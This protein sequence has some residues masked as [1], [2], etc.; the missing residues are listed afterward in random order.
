[1]G[2]RVVIILPK[3]RTQARKIFEYIKLNSPQNAKKFIINL[4]EKL[5]VIAQNPLGYP[6]IYLF[7][8]DYRFCKYM[9]SWKIIFRVTNTHLIFLGIVHSARH[10]REI[11]KLK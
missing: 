9:K 7:K 6:R 4:D 10:R 5:D 1:M 3:F 2:S 8:D 11:L